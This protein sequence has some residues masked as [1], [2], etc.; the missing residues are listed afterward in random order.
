[1]T[2]LQDM[3]TAALAYAGAGLRVLPV[4]SVD[5]LGECTCGSA[6]CN[7]PGK[8]PRTAH[9]VREASADPDVIAAWW[10]RWPGANV[11]L[12]TGP[13]A[14]EGLIGWWVLDLDRPKAGEIDGRDA[15]EVLAEIH[16]GLPQGA[17][18]LT[19]SGGMHLLFRWPESGP[20]VRS[21]AR[22]L[23]HDGAWASA[24]TRGLGGYIVAPPSMHATGARYAWGEG[25]GLEALCA[26]P[27]WLE[28][29]VRARDESKVAAAAGKALG[30]AG[31]AGEASWEVG[32]DRPSRYVAGALAKAC[33]RLEK[34]T[35]GQRH[36]S[37]LREAR[38]I[39]GWLHLVS[40]PDEEQ[41]TAALA[42]AAM[43]AGLPE[44]DARRTARDGVQHG[45]NEPRD[46]P[47]LPEGMRDSQGGGMAAGDGWEDWGSPDAPETLDPGEPTWDGENDDDVVP[48]VGIQDVSEED[49]DY[50]GVQVQGRPT[51]IINPASN[52]DRQAVV[53]EQ[54]WK[55]LRGLRGEGAVYLR[56]GRLARIS[57]GAIL[58]VTP[59]ALI[60]T[61]VKSARWVKL[62][63]P[64]A[65][66]ITAGE[67]MLED[68]AEK[69]PT[70]LLDAMLADPDPRLPQIERLV[71]APF[72]HGEGEV[73]QPGYH[74]PSRSYLM[75]QPHKR[76]PVDG[77]G[78]AVDLLLGEWLGDFPFA[79]DADRAH[80][81]AALLTPIVRAEIDGPCPLVMIE[82]PERR[83]GKTLLMELL[84]EVSSGQTPN[85]AG[86][87]HDDE[88]R[89]KTWSMLVRRGEAVICVDNVS[90]RMDDD[91]LCRILTSG[92]L[93]E[94]LLGTQDAIDVPARSVW[95]ATGNNA[96]MSQ[97][98][99]G[100]SIRVRLDSQTDTPEA[101]QEFRIAD[102]KAWTRARVDLLRSAALE[103][104]AAWHR[105]GRP[106]SG[107]RLGK[108]EGWSRVVGG[109]LE[110]AG[111]RGFLG[112]RA[113]QADAADPERAEWRSLLEVWMG[114]EKRGQAMQAGEIARMAVEAGLLLAVVGDGNDV[115]RARRMGQALVARRGRVTRVGETG[116]RVE[117]VKGAKGSICWKPQADAQIHAF[118]STG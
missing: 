18:S 4:H 7:S 10:A 33:E 60:S 71:R 86:W 90:G 73:V 84:T 12:A 14:G 85:P 92:A 96:L 95:M 106:Y 16:G 111:V 87:A 68:D 74:A 97:D 61:L 56:G 34:L 17:V 109:I 23:R 13:A 35:A 83:T 72:W 114:P 107:A 9:G 51:V 20:A 32:G 103:L 93:M 30:G 82:A 115:S 75:G 52:G 63:P 2:Q 19:G 37:L 70:Q 48:G 31:G 108:F 99:I 79:S 24:D 1:M 62:R 27:A 55:V 5:H 91:P 40:Q 44:K 6:S 43:R 78:D 57:N 11:G 77:V 69:I 81:L 47:P 98:L 49:P 41:A 67:A 25:A 59:G 66:E 53:L 89:R 46:L 76:S 88:E 15:L 21:R 80:A 64:K 26:A 38:T 39:G 36:A 110:V 101:R 29:A 50:A 54:T 65:R 8:H 45:M 94:R 58:D 116:V 102:I 117:Q 113:E 112:N 118:R 22:V 100:R 105:Q 104:V 28:A 42:E 3:M